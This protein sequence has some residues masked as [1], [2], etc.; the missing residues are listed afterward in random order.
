[1]GLSHECWYCGW[2]GSTEDLADDGY[3][4]P[5]CGM[6]QGEVGTNSRL[7]LQEHPLC[8]H[9]LR[10]GRYKKSKYVINGVA[11]CDQHYKEEAID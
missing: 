7:F 10:A 2:T 1:M 5:Q 4:C 9:C 8:S 6:K 11:V 3:Y